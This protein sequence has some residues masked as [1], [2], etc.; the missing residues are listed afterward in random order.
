[1]SAPS[2]TRQGVRNL[3]HLPGRRLKPPRKE[4]VKVMAHNC[5]DHYRTLCDCGFFG[6]CN[7][8]G[9]CSFCGRLFR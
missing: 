2:V 1:M 9:E 6:D 5:Y 4:T 8:P 3:N 7:C